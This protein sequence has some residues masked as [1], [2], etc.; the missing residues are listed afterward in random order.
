MLEPHARVHQAVFFGH[1]AFLCQP[2]KVILL[3]FFFRR[4][5]LRARSGVAGLVFA[6]QCMSRGHELKRDTVMFDFF[7]CNKPGT[8][9]QVRPELEYV[10]SGLPSIIA[11]V[12]KVGDGA[13]HICTSTYKTQHTPRL[14]ICYCFVPKDCAPAKSNTTGQSTCSSAC[15]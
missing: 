14:C 2:K 6:V 7:K 3:F 13:I 12:L 1:F 9:R 15:L 11:V 8:P 5:S 4:V 10:V